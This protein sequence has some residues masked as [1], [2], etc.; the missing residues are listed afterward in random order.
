MADVPEDFHELFN[1]TNET[2]SIRQSTDGQQ[3]AIHVKCEPD[4][5]TCNLRE[6]NTYEFSEHA[7]F[8]PTVVNMLVYS[9]QHISK[10]QSNVNH[11]DNW[12]S[13]IVTIKK[14][15]PNYC[16]K[17]EIKTHEIFASNMGNYGEQNEC[18]GLW[19]DNTESR[20]CC[21]EPQEAISYMENKC[22][23]MEFTTGN[24]PVASNTSVINKCSQPK[25]EE[26]L[27]SDTSNVILEYNKRPH[28]RHNHIV[29]IKYEP[30]MCIDSTSHG[31]EAYTHDS[32]GPCKYEPCSSDTCSYEVQTS[33]ELKSGSL[34]D[35]TSNVE[36]STQ[37]NALDKS[38]SDQ[39][40]VKRQEHVISAKCESFIFDGNQHMQ[41]EISDSFTEGFDPSDKIYNNSSCNIQS[42]SNSAVSTIHS[43]SLVNDDITRSCNIQS[44]S[45]SAV[46]TI[47]SESLVNDD[48]TR[49][50]KIQAS[51]N[52]AVSTIHSESLV[53]DDITR[54]CNIQ[55]SSNSAVSTIQSESLVND[56]ITRR[57]RQIF[58]CDICDYSVKNHSLFQ[59]HMVKHTD[60]NPYKCDTCDYSTAIHVCLIQ[61]KLI[62][63]RGNPYRCETCGYSAAQREDIEKHKLKHTNEKPHKCNLCDFSAMRRD[64]VEK[65]M[66]IHIGEQPYKCD[67]CDYSTSRRRNLER[68]ME[69]IH[70]KE[71]TYKCNVCD[72]GTMRRD[73][74]E[75][76]M[77]Q[78][79]GM[80]P[81]NC[82]ICSYSTMRRDN[83]ERHMIK[84]TGEKPYKCDICAFSAIH[85]QNLEQHK[86]KHTGEKRYMC[87][88]CGFR[89]ASCHYLKQHKITHSGE[90]PYKCDT[91]EFSSALRKYLT[92][93]KRLQHPEQYKMKHAGP[94]LH[95]CDVCDYTTLRRDNLQRH[96]TK[97]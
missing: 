88:T 62:H 25:E 11:D 4:I 55:S 24:V 82:D 40:S 86:V 9:N 6:Q 57:K 27:Y 52:S 42:N 21:G 83:L 96:K 44:S 68:H 47:D 19:K 5:D 33:L 60:D 79:T 63:K 94:T 50:C 32:S 73:L 93:H 26:I 76:H 97:H 29:H 23:D 13:G 74:F 53:K 64:I 38:V 46:S 80:K 87:D 39:E 75:K 12:K 59:K 69:T 30:D 81:Y 78:H 58:T 41:N 3:H 1:S 22:C 77:M 89:T 72:F 37:R 66:V 49:S 56:D 67:K 35:T 51:S 7:S 31:F 95:K 17:E 36:C 20:V 28:D 18:P 70:T 8:K 2:A 54:S 85:Q 10:Q 92:R 48:I 61:H 16:A 65:H 91:C 15:T 14:E 84:H 45:N 71:K 43:E 34:G 90:K